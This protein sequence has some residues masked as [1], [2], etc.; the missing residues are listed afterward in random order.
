MYTQQHAIS[1]SAK[2]LLETHPASV[3]S[4]DFSGGNALSVPK[5]TLTIIPPRGHL[6]FGVLRNTSGSDGVVEKRRRLNADGEA[7]YI[8]EKCQ[9]TFM[10]K[11]DLKRHERVHSDERPYKCGV[12]DKGFTRSD[13]LACHQR[14]HTGEKPFVCKECKRK[15]AK[16]SSLTSHRRNIHAC[17]KPYICDIC[18]DGFVT[19]RSLAKHRDYHAGETSFLCQHCT[20]EFK[21]KSN[22]ASHQRSFAVPELEEKKE[23]INST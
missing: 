19:R 15:F 22:L 7:V 5:S 8:C 13:L 9:Y 4:E 18:G 12:C 11:N 23:K 21:S 2:T 20:R 10:R 6:E 3:S 1:T 17:E 16:K 14:T